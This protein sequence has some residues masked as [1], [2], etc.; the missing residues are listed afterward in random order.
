MFEVRGEIS[1]FAAAVRR[2][3]GFEIIDEEELPA[4]DDKSPVVYL[5]VSDASAL[6]NLLTLWRRYQSDT[7]RYGEKAWADIF[8][9]LRDLRPWGP[10]DRVQEE[11]AGFLADE[12]A[13]RVD[14]E[15]VRIEV[16]L[17]FRSNAGRGRE[18][19]AEVSAFADRLGG[20]VVSV[21]RIDAIA[22]HA[23]L[24]DLPVNAIRGIV[25]RAQDSI[26]TM[27]AV[28]YLRPQSIADSIELAEQADGDQGGTAT[29]R[30]APILA[31]LD[32]VP[33][34]AH[35]ALAAHVS[36]E[37][38]FDLE[39]STPVAHR[40]HGTA[41]A[42]LIVHGDRNRS[43]SQLP[44]RIHVVPVLGASE[45]FSR[46]RLI[47]DV[48]YTAVLRMRDGA[49][50]TAPG[51]IIVNLSLGNPRRPFHGQVSPWARLLDRLAYQFGLLFIVSA[52]NHKG[53]FSLPSFE[54]LDQFASAGPGERAEGV[55]A[56]LGAI[57]AD[58]RLISPAE[59]VNGLT[60]GASNQDGIGDVSRTTAYVNVDPYGTLVTA[61][62]SSALGPGFGNSVKPDVLLPGSRE[63]LT[64]VTSGSRLNVRPGAPSRAGG[65]KVAAP[66]DA[67]QENQFGYTGGTSAASALAARTAHRIHDA[68]EATYGE[69]FLDLAPSLRAV[70]LKA[71]LAHPAAWP[72]QSAELIKKVLGP[73]DGKLHVRQKDNIRRL[74]G[75]GVVDSE[76]A[77]ACAGDRATL[78]AVGE[79]GANKSI[80][81]MVPLPSVLSG[82]ALPHSVSATLAWFTPVAVGRQSYRVV[83]LRLLEPE[84]LPRLAVTPHGEQ[85][86]QNQ[87]RRGTLVSRRWLGQRAPL[88]SGE[89]S[90]LRLA[91]QREPDQGAT[92][93]EPAP[94]GLAVTLAMPGVE[95]IYAQ[96][97]QRLG[98]RNVARE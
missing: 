77:V 5:L 30:G 17:V 57:V 71:L 89:S 13:G 41:M 8:G 53:A 58:R 3:G 27:D 68:L 33:V 42:S 61:N 2:V 83:R 31:M 19:Q 20:T 76:D 72:V 60:I 92:S 69:A 16:E 23:L 44:R 38:L 79:I 1:A 95:Q 94:F 73:D 67:G 40:V 34:A 46:N 75:Y 52:G 14:T 82:K 39:P 55:V 28:M 12:I 15:L 10:N 88:I 48:M 45:Q 97:A 74:L 85:P 47:V 21:A 90:F 91:V 18:A 56:A 54:T 43:E 24:V 84:G 80:E 81:V 7:L 65:L 96:V 49:E 37:D 6:R 93:D 26:A 51:V 50:P 35:P 66:P 22:Y 59:H 29:P 87:A 98:I 9:L 11:D 32:G 63:H 25:D 86:D 64:L 78:W 62:P 36:L 70:L 4:D